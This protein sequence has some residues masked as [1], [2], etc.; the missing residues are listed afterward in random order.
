MHDT[1]L[2][3]S[4]SVEDYLTGERG[5]EV[6][7]E[8]I[9]GQAYAMV[10]AGRSHGLIVTALAL[11]I[12]PDTRKSGCQLFIADMK[13]RLSI[14]GDDIFYYPDL[15]LSCDPGDR[16]DYFITRPCL[17]IEVLS[18]TTERIDRREKLLAYQTLG[19]LQE[20][21]L[22]TQDHPRFEIFRRANG[23]RREALTDGSLQSIA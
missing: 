7:H 9:A 12:G 17:I 13:V 23:W 19:S 15:V 16:E 14:A 1:G 22:A 4:V 11:A 20:Y 18:K 6:R 8:Y 10:G 2:S 3:P 21:V 5:G